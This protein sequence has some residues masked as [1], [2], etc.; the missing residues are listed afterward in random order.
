MFF[1]RLKYYFGFNCSYAH[2]PSNDTAALYTAAL[3]AHTTTMSDTAVSVEVFPDD[4]V[5]LFQDND[6]DDD[7][8][9]NKYLVK[10]C[11]NYKK[12]LLKLNGRFNMV[13]MDCAACTILTQIDDKTNVIKHTLTVLYKWIQTMTTDIALYLQTTD[14]QLHFT[15]IQLDQK[16]LSLAHLAQVAKHCNVTISVFKPKIMVVMKTFSLCPCKNRLPSLMHRNY[17]FLNIL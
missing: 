5:E 6:G 4:D 3:L 2:L 15:L 10:F 1:Y 9:P 16:L 14:D 8:L 13:S 12:K 11:A 7:V 17:M